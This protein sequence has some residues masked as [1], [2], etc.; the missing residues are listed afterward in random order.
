MTKDRKRRIA[1]R[2]AALGF[3]LV[4]IP[5]NQAMAQTSE[6]QPR[7]QWPG[8]IQTDSTL[9]LR[10]ATELLAVFISHSG[11]GGNTVE[12]FDAAVSG[13]KNALAARADSLG[14]DFAAIGV[15]TNWDIREGL[16]YLLD[17]ESTNAGRLNFGPWAEVVAG[18]NYID[19][20]SS[21]L[22]HPNELQ[23]A[24]PQV[25]IF[26]RRLQVFD[27]GRPLMLEPPEYRLLVSGGDGIVEWAEG[28]WK[29]PGLEALVVNPK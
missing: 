6:Y 27:A 22:I 17:G 19:S 12:G 16:R 8:V 21:W 25:I 3:L 15:A 13:M 1:W 23:L 4:P 20:A 7:G 26:T 11:C 2:T 18:R 5:L 28:G 10:S 24:V 29:I 9:E 14:Y